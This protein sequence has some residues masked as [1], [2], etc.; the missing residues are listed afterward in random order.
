VVAGDAVSA[1]GEADAKAAANS[2]LAFLREWTLRED[3]V[4]DDKPAALTVLTGVT[5]QLS[6]H[7]AAAWQQNLNAARD[8][9]NDD[10][11]GNVRSLVFSAIGSPELHPPAAEAMVTNR[12]F[13]GD[14]FVTYDEST[15]G[16]RVNVDYSADLVRVTKASKPQS[17]RMSLALKGEVSLVMTPD[18]GGRWSIFSWQGT[19]KTTEPVR[20]N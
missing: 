7:A 13:D 9:Q 20:I 4:R 2:A 1:H 12:T 19:Y 16:L 17:G 15:D 10:A 8:A 5:P 6:S 14:A 18:G 11:W 3:L